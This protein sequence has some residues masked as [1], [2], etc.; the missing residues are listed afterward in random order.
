MPQVLIAARGRVVD[1]DVDAAE[2]VKGGT[3]VATAPSHVADADVETAFRPF[4][5]PAAT[6]SASAPAPAPT[7]STTTAAPSRQSSA[8]RV[9]CPD[10]RR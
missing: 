4:A 8:A 1:Q 9:L 3:D 6:E 5:D 10:P 7:S 2:G